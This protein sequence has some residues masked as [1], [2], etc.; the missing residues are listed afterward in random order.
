LIG[1][2]SRE[3]Y[4]S[5]SILYAQHKT[6][7]GRVVDD[8][9]EILPYV[10]IVIN[11]TVKVGRTDLKGFFQIDI[12]ISVKKISFESLGLESATVRPVDNCNEVE[13]VMK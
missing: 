8:N 1:P 5:T 3:A 4:T 10:S 6:I 2:K 7:K 11:D 12:P 9:L 13:V